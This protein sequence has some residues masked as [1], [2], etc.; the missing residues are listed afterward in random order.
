MPDGIRVEGRSVDWAASWWAG[1]YLEFG[2]F[3]NLPC[4]GPVAAIPLALRVVRAT[5]RVRVYGTKRILWI[6][7]F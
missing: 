1:D 7:N 2:G 5:S 6:S 4:S 3:K